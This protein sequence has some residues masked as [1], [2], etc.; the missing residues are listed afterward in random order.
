MLF[1]EWWT[2]R[3]Y[4]APRVPLQ[5]L[6]LRHA[7]QE[8]PPS[9]IFILCGCQS[10][11]HNASKRG[12]YSKQF[13]HSVKEN[14]LS[15]H[16]SHTGKQRDDKVW[17]A[18]KVLK[19]FFKQTKYFPALDDKQDSAETKGHVTFNLWT[20]SPLGSNRFDAYD[21]CCSEIIYIYVLGPLQRSFRKFKASFR[22]FISFCQSLEDISEPSQRFP[23]MLTTKFS[24]LSQPPSTTNEAVRPGVRSPHHLILFFSWTLGLSL[25]VMD[26]RS[27]VTRSSNRW[28]VRGQLVSV[29]ASH[30]F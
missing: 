28:R 9:P 16:K 10:H 29:L 13:K 7:H 1:P 8:I 2:R 12:F 18:S 22:A 26:G 23:K 21:S 20:I 15:C 24:C 30:A 19:I 25:L 14:I 4:T 27:Q 11:H 6:G 5:V 17:S 3:P